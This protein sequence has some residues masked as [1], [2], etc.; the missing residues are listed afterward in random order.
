MSGDD[1][2]FYPNFKIDLK[3]NNHL[4]PLALI[5]PLK[6]I[7]IIHVFPHLQVATHKPYLHFSST[8]TTFSRFTFTSLMG[9]TSMGLPFV[10]ESITFSILPSMILPSPPLLLPW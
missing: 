2:T 10:V 8:S 9:I 7:F 5:P 4:N 6:L 3:K 1:F